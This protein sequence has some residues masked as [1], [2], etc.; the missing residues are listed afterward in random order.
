MEPK[1]WH[2]WTYVWNRSNITDIENEPVV[3]KGERTGGE[4]GARWCKLLYTEW[5]NNTV[6]LYSAENYIQCP[7]INY[8]GKEYKKEYI[9]IYV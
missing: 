8:N 4:D 1:L 6:L 5:V 2:K 9:Y 3:A 7:M